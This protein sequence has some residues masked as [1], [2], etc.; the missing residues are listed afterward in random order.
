MVRLRRC[1]W[2]LLSN[3]YYWTVNKKDIHE[4]INLEGKILLCIIYLKKLTYCKLCSLHF[5][6]WFSVGIG[7]LTIQTTAV[8]QCQSTHVF[9]SWKTVIVKFNLGSVC[10]WE[11]KSFCNRW[12][13]LDISYCCFLGFG[14][15]V[16]RDFS[17][18]WDF[19]ACL[20]FLVTV[21][22]TY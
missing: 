1:D 18:V 14:K 16:I 20:N 8:Y 17:V 12:W 3:W 19:F 13:W 4:N 9:G 6:F 2:Y 22:V 15:M 21:Y 10:F 7:L 11:A 5:F